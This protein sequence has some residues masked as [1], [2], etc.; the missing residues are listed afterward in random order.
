MK[1]T[2]RKIKEEEALFFEWLQ[3]G[4][5]NGWISEPYCDIHDG[6][7]MSD[8]EMENWP[9]EDSCMFAVRLYGV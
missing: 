6:I 5:N 4:K 1:K 3:I 8:K 9:D 2:I 7:I